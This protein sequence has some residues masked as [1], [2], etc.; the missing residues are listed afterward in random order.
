MTRSRHSRLLPLIALA[1]TLTLAACGGQQADTRPEDEQPGTPLSLSVTGPASVSPGAE[2]SLSATAAGT[3]GAAGLIT[4]TAEAGA[5][6]PETGPA[7]T[8][9]A[10]LEPGI[11]TITATIEAGT[12][13]A[14]DTIS[15]QVTE[16]PP[17]EETPLS[18]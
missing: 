6:T 16:E 2:A 7:T 14:S 12:E 8:W 11:Q 15:I 9:T 10:P 13:T 17:E 1:L 5:L 18:L 3:N 4:W